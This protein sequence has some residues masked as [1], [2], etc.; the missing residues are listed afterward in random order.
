LIR[1]PDVAGVALVAEPPGEG[2]AEHVR[3]L[4]L[5]LPAHG[6]EPVV[7]VPHD[8][9]HLDELRT[10]CE[11]VTVPFRRDYAHPHDEVRVLAE[12]VPV[13][14]R[15]A[16]VHAHSA[17]A[18]VIARAAARLARRP[19]VYSPHGFPFVGEMSTARRQFGLLVERL[20]APMTATLICVCEFERR[21]ARQKRVRPRQVA[22]VHNGSPPCSERDRVEMPSGLIVGTLSALR[23]AK[24]L[25]CM[26]D[27]MPKIKAAV[28]EATLVVVGSGPLEAELRAH[29]DRLGIEVT[30]LPFEPPP[31]RY[32]HA[33]DVYVLSSA[34]EA[35]P[36]SVL[37]AQACGVPQVVSAVGGTRESVVPETGIV[38]PP[39][40]PDALAEAVVQLLRDPRRRAAMSEAS[41]V[42][43]AQRFTVERMVADTAAVYDRVLAGA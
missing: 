25:D 22:V 12:L 20:L 36:I 33:F 35:F 23:P 11:V 24:A 9:A 43:H 3:R 5:G 30:W 6:Y 38:V 32:L 7:V 17:K 29:A 41:R 2:V 40:D 1:L 31:Q 39:R 4:A 13:L 21:L 10:A 42:R 16:L 37:E 14:R 19:V 15:T 28:P 18:G 8:Y 26:L 34:W 27:A